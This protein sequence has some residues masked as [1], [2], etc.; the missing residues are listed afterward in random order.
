MSKIIRNLHP[1]VKGLSLHWLFQ[2]YYFTEEPKAI[3]LNSNT[4]LSSRICLVHKTS[5]P[6]DVN[7]IIQLT[8]T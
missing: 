7:E 2:K 4:V 3:F 5:P 6:K 1:T 8:L